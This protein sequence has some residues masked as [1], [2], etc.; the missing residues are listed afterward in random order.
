MAGG[1]GVDLAASDMWISVEGEELLGAEEDALLSLRLSLNARPLR[2]LLPLLLLPPLLLLLLAVLLALLL[3]VPF[4]PWPSSSVWLRSRAMVTEDLF[5]ALLDF[6]TILAAVDV[7][8]LSA[9]EE[10]PLPDSS[11]SSELLLGL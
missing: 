3:L 5:L 4:L 6:R 8:M 11:S 9:V 2:R 7:D 1:D 10:D